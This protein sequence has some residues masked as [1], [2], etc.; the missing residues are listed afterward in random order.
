MCQQSIRWPVIDRL[1]PLDNCKGNNN[2]GQVTAT[3]GKVKRLPNSSRSPWQPTELRLLK[4]RFP[5]IYAA[6]LLGNSSGTS[7]VTASL[8]TPCTLGRTHQKTQV[9]KP[10]SGESSL[11]SS[12]TNFVPHPLITS[13]HHATCTCVHSDRLVVLL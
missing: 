13:R 4:K 12:S 11:F 8:S 10:I 2:T 5:I 1:E 6:I 9:R 3:E 7:L